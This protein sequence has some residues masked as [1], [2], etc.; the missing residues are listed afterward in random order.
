ML[1]FI[2]VL[3]FFGVIQKYP[4]LDFT[5]SV[6]EENVYSSIATFTFTATGCFSAYVMT[7]IN[8]ITL[9]LT[10]RQPTQVVLPGNAIKLPDAIL[11]VMA[12]CAN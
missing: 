12:M 4:A 6:F 11:G 5:V 8:I 1:S 2:K 9:Q 3:A 10:S 7:T